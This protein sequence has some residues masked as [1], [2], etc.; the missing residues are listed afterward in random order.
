MGAAG[1]A[2]PTG[3]DTL[4][5][6]PDRHARGDEHDL[7]SAAHGLPLLSSAV[8]GLQHF[9]QV[10]A[11][12]RVGADLG[13]VARGL[14]LREELIR[15]ASPTAA[16]IDSQ[17]LKAAEKGGC[18]S[19]SE[20]DAAGH[21]AGNKVKDRALHALSMSKVC[22][23]GS[24]SIPRI[25]DATPRAWCSTRSANAF[26]GSNSR[27]PI[28]ATTPTKSRTPSPRLRSCASKSLSDPKTSKASSCYR[29]AGWSSALSLG[30]VETA[31]YE[32]LANTLATFATFGA[33]QLAM[34]RLA[35]T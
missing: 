7:L 31:A 34:R 27:G 15:E 3:Q 35:R 10:P 1:A 14:A 6:A 32:N 23:Y 17:S 29:T 8:Y 12:R 33:I 20:D 24:S 26:P 21:D 25:Q 9:P 30:S 5:T 13:G 2:D 4:T 11:R 19:R 28:P 18:K 16:I 22:R